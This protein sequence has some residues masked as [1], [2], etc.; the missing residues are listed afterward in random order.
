MIGKRTARD[1]LSCGFG[2]SLLS[3]DVQSAARV[4][5]RC[6]APSPQAAL[7]DAQA[8]D[9]LAPFLS[10][11]DSSLPISGLQSFQRAGCT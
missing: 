10:F 3:A 2:G 1:K 8:A 11:G 9:A 6:A 5:V 7:P 4:P